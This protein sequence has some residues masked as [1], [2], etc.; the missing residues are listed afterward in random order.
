MELCC[1]QSLLPLLFS[2]TEG[3]RILPEVP[4]CLVN[5]ARKVKLLHER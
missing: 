3:R 1:L 4:I 2:V 5:I